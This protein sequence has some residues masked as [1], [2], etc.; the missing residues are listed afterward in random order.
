MGVI[1]I[2]KKEMEQSSLQIDINKLIEGNQIPLI[3]DTRSLNHVCDICLNANCSSSDDGDVAVV[4]PR[5]GTND[6]SD[7]GDVKPQNKTTKVK[8]SLREATKMMACI[9]IE[10]QRRQLMIKTEQLTPKRKRKVK[11]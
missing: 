8:I 4:K 7:D 6:I 3:Y 1:I 10:E 2:K 5:K 9:S 11:H